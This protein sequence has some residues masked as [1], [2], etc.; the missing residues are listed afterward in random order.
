VLC[1][2]GVLREAISPLVAERLAIRRKEDALAA[3]VAAREKEKAAGTAATAAGGRLGGR[4]LPGAL[5][6]TSGR[7]APAAGAARVTIGALP[8]ARPSA[9]AAPGS[10]SSPSP[11]PP[12]PSAAQPARTAGEAELSDLAATL[13]SGGAGSSWQSNDKRQYAVSAEEIEAEAKTL[14]NSRLA[15]EVMLIVSQRQGACLCTGSACVCTRGSQLAHPCAAHGAAI[16]PQR[17]RAGEGEAHTSG[18]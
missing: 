9:T 4:T 7:A 12:P 10:S 6:G 14:T 5:R 8:L 1:G 11:S 2:C 18:G 13:G 3:A 15:R 16:R 17:V